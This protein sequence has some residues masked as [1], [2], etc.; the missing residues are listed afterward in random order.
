MRSVAITVSM[1][2]LLG[3]IAG[4]LLISQYEIDPQIATPDPKPE[5][6]TLVNQ[7]ITTEPIPDVTASNQQAATEES[8]QLPNEEI[9]RLKSLGLTEAEIEEHR[10]RQQLDRAATQRFNATVQMDNLSPDK[11]LPEVRE[12]FK[13]L[14]LE[15]AYDVERGNAGFIDG[16]FIA[17]LTSANPLA[18]AGFKAGDRLVSFDGMPLQDPSEVAHLFVELG[19]QFEIC[20]DRDGNQ[21]CQIITLNEG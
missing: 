1:I 15:P 21:Y 5:P 2:V 9:A 7:S 11:V 4:Y 20:A 18:K 10:Q 6:E 17:E 3:F 16:M 19:E 14:T 12:M 8:D 13:T